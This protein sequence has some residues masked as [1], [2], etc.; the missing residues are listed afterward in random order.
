MINNLSALATNVIIDILV[1]V[2]ILGFGIVS[3][4][5]GFVDCLF[6]F[7]ST[8]LALIL[9]FSLAK[10]FVSWTGGLFGLELK[11]QTACT[12][13]FSGIVGFNIDVSAE[14]MTAALQEKQLPQFLVNL[15]VEMFG[16]AELELGTTLAM[17]V[18]SAL[19]S[20]ISTLISFFVIFALCKTV[21]RLLR[22]I[23]SSV[24]QRIPLVGGANRIL[25]FFAGL[26]QGMLIVCGL[27]SV[28]SV[29]PA[30]GMIEFFNTTTFVGWLYNHNLINVILGWVL[31]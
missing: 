19:G 21:F 4:K 1:V 28:L 25:G 18:G 9:A 16:N 29:I 2:V 20:L 27:L 11:L 5:R 12:N 7:A 13:A 15:V 8:I 3:A 17:L 23:L 24:I 26:L 6:S 31:V 22:G 30:Q 10:S 14:G